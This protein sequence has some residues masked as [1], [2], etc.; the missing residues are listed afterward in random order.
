M[1]KYFAFVCKHINYFGYIKYLPSLSV[2]HKIG[3]VIF[4][5]TSSKSDR[6]TMMNGRLKVPSISLAL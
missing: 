4:D 5:L 1:L 3:T 6:L 2:L